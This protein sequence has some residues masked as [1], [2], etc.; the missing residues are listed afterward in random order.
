M[1]SLVNSTKCL[2][3]NEHQSFTNP[4]KKRREGT[5]P[6]SVKLAWP[7]YESTARILKIQ[8]NNSTTQ[9]P[10]WIQMQKSSTILKRDGVFYL[11][12]KY[13]SASQA[14]LWLPSL[15]GGFLTSESPFQSWAVCWV[16]FGTLSLAE[17]SP[18]HLPGSWCR[19]FSK[20]EPYT[21]WVQFSCRLLGKSL[22]HFWANHLKVF[23]L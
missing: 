11:F 18:P 19:D 21:A 14:S 12:C 8:K 9:Y 2:K 13:G 5:S 3:N 17:T 6:Y 7:Q 10:L 22:I 23:M 4:S 20:V 1:V 16:G 15:A